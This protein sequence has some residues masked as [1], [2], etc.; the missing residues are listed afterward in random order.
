MDTE[1][2]MWVVQCIGRRKPR[3][4]SGKYMV[5]SI[6]VDFHNAH[7]T[8]AVKML[9]DKYN[10]LLFMGAGRLTPK[11]NLGQWRTLST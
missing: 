6:L 9:C 4:L 10:I 5:S 3:L 11:A 1:A 2:M 7:K 8:D